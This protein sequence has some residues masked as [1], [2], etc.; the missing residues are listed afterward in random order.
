MW[1]DV[2]TSK[3]NLSFRGQ[4]RPPDADMEERE[5]FFFFLSRDLGGNALNIYF[6][7]RETSES[8]PPQGFPLQTESLSGRQLRSSYIQSLECLP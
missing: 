2:P 5:L 4:G 3:T 7:G 1:L 6:C 8:E